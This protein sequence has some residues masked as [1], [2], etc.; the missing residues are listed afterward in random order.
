QGG[1]ASRNTLGGAARKEVPG[2]ASCE[3]GVTPLLCAQRYDMDYLRR[4]TIEGDTPSGSVSSA[5]ITLDGDGKVT[6]T[7]ESTDPFFIEKDT[8]LPPPGF[9]VTTGITQFQEIR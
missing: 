6:G 3:A 2:G 7:P 4:F 8:R 5:L 1:I 9:T